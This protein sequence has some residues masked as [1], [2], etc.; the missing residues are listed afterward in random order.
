MKREIVPE[1][2]EPGDKKTAAQNVPVRPA[3]TLLLVDWEAKSPRLL[4]GRRKADLAFMPGLTVFPGGAMDREDA[5]MPSAD[6]LALETQHRLRLRASSLSQRGARG[7]A[8]AAIRELYE[9]TGILYG[10]RQACTSKA[11]NWQAFAA[12]GVMPALS[13]LHLV[14]RAITPPLRPRRFDTRFFLGDKKYVAKTVHLEQKTDL[15]KTEWLPLVEIF[16]RP[17]AFITKQILTDLAPLLQK[18]DEKALA[19]PFPFY[20]AKGKKYYCEMIG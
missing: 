11:D 14:A 2:V 15:E 18:Y 3:A 16:E 1:F 12:Y 8:M 13:D 19:R 9:E 5:A 17:L 4:V 20:Y 6:E 7:L 10:V